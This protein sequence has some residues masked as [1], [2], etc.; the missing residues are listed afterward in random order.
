MYLFTA[1]VAVNKYIETG[2]Y[3][4]AVHAYINIR[5][6]AG[7]VGTII[8]KYAEDFPEVTEYP[9]TINGYNGNLIKNGIDAFVKFYNENDIEFLHDELVVYSET[10]FVGTL[11]G[12]VILNGKKTLLD[13]KTSKRFYIEQS[14]QVSS[15]VFAYEEQTGDLIEQIVIVRL[16]KYTGKYHLKYV[17]LEKARATYMNIF[18]NL[19]NI[20]YEKA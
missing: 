3:G 16:D 2:N 12:I 14:Y 20:H 10:G 8:H 6:E 1:K 13:W 9:E 19:L 17:D 11:D 7:V 18:K 4:A 5:D 15:Y